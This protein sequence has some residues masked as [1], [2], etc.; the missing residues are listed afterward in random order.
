MAENVTFRFAEREDVPLILEFVKALA[1]YEK[2]P[3]AVCATEE[4]LEEWLFDKERAEVLFLIV[5]GKEAGFAL[6]FESFASY[7]GKGGIYLDDLYV[8]PEYRGKGY[9]KELFRRL[10]QITRE[11][12]GMRIEW[13]CLKSNLPSIGFYESVGG[14]QMEISTTFRLENEALEKFAVDVR[15]GTEYNLT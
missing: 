2:M 5:S 13:L 15:E 10:A 7:P 1:E 6:F 4:D 8:K 14:K 12:G 11:R 3:D 9:G